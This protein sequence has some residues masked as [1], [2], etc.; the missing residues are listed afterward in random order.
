MNR[1]RNHWIVA[2]IA[3]ATAFATGWVF[4]YRTNVIDR[5]LGVE[6]RMHLHDD[7]LITNFLRNRTDFE[8]LR[9]MIGEDTGLLFVSDDKVMYVDSAATNIGAASL[10]EYRTLLSR[11]GVK[12]ISISF[13]RRTVELTS[14]RR[15]MGTHNS[16]KSYIYIE[17]SVFGDELFASLD[18]FSDSEVGSGLRRID[19][20][21]Y[22][23]FEGY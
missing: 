6:S 20:R 13:D 18:R 21:W 11:I 19:G 3:V 23:H 2:L 9:K 12:D 22:L 8:L 15:G 5:V 7:E 1:K 17:D 10:D 4:I 16:Q 14:S